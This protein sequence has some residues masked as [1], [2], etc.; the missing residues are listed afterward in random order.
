MT[1]LLTVFSISSF[2]AFTQDQRILNKEST[3][4]NQHSEAALNLFNKGV[5]YSNNKDYVPANRNY[6]MAIALDSDYIDAYNNLGLNLYE[7]NLLDS[8]GYYLR[9]SLRKF[10]SG[11]TAL[12][13]PGL[14]EE[15]AGIK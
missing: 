3:N 10:P 5:N 6:E 7:M 13:N 1:I 9:I 11:T 14:V 4:S 2:F 12:Q 8:A 15:K